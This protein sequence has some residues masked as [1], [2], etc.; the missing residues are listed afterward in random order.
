MKADELAGAW[1][2]FR[3]TFQFGDGFYFGPIFAAVYKQVDI[4]IAN[5]TTN[6]TIR[7][8]FLS[9]NSYGMPN[10]PSWP[11]MVWLAVACLLGVALL[12]CA[13]ALSLF[14]ANLCAKHTQ[15]PKSLI[16]TCI[17]VS[18]IAVAVACLLFPMG[19]DRNFDPCYPYQS[20]EYQLHMVKVLVAASYAAQGLKPPSDWTP[21][22]P[23]IVNTSAVIFQDW[24]C[25]SDMTM[26][27]RVPVCKTSTG[28]Y[29]F[30]GHCQ[31]RYG[32]FAVAGGSA[33]LLIAG[34]G[35]LISHCVQERRDHA[36]TSVRESHSSKRV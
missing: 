4:P 8:S 3:S 23:T 20:E 11:T 36:Y 27:Q 28:G 16:G 17:L 12:L 13:F 15:F 26:N 34:L 21:L 19:T 25:H 32:E 30:G 2:A 35:I 24:T 10:Q 18:A 6:E 14:L 5:S 29:D 31:V 1:V 7:M 9:R 33:A 22:T